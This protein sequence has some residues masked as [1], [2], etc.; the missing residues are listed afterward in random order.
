MKDNIQTYYSRRTWLNDPESFST[1][2]VVA[3]DGE[4]TYEDSI[5]PDRR[6]SLKISDCHQ[7]ICLHNGS[8]DTKEDFVKKMK[9]LR[10]EIDLFINHLESDKSPE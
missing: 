7:I 8:Y 1:G 2:S 5:K 3:Y 6:L 4:I 9:L 10:D